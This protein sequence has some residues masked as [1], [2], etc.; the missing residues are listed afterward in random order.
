ML[1]QLKIN[2]ILLSSDGIQIPKWSKANRIRKVVKCFE[3]SLGGFPLFVGIAQMLIPT[4]PIRMFPSLFFSDGESE[5]NF[6]EILKRVT[7]GIFSYIVVGFGINSGQIIFALHLIIITASLNSSLILLQHGIKVQAC[8]RPPPLIYREIQLL[9]QCYNEIS[10]GLLMPTIILYNILS[11]CVSSYPLI[12]EYDKMES[13]FTFFFLINIL[14]V[15]IMVLFTCLGLPGEV[16]K[17]GKELVGGVGI[18]ANVDYLRNRV[19][20]CREVRIVKKFWKSCP[21]VK[22]FFFSSS[23]FERCTQLSILDFAINITVNL[24]LLSK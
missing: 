24:I 21:N 2:L 11:L 5:Y 22:I 1:S 9:F 18:E 12:S 14:V 7:A 4:S 19:G 13:I 10:K 20:C 17:T 15:A 23:F 3:L 16:Y 6:V 8:S